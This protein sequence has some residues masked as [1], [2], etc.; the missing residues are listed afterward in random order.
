[1]EISFPTSGFSFVHWQQQKKTRTRSWRPK[2]KE[3]YLGT[4]SSPS[5]I[6][7]FSYMGVP[8]S[9]KS[10]IIFFV[11]PLVGPVGQQR[12]SWMWRVHPWEKR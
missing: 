11:P 6:I 10:K 1:M 9:T 4:T 7:S 2:A 3:I 8:L 12:R 5:A